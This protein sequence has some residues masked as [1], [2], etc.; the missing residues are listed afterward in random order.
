VVEI[1]LDFTLT[2]YGGFSPTSGFDAAAVSVA[3]EAEALEAIYD[4]EIYQCDF[5]TARD[6][7]ADPTFAITPEYSQGDI[8]ELCIRSSDYP[9]ASIVDITSL[10]RV[11]FK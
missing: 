3:E 2:L 7:S 10:A 1:P 6:I 11:A 4:V 8:V 9:Q 5:P